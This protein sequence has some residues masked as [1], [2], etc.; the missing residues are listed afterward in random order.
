MALSRMPHAGDFQEIPG[1]FQELRQESS[2]VESQML[3][4]KASKAWNDPDGSFIN[5][6]ME[7]DC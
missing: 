6:I 5:G 3:S 4:T 2:R 7:N 1:D